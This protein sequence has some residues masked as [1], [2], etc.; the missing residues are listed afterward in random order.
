MQ[1]RNCQTMHCARPTHT[2]V[3]ALGDG[4]CLMMVY[5]PLNL[6][7]CPVSE[8]AINHSH[9]LILRFAQITCCSSVGPTYFYPMGQRCR[10]RF[11]TPH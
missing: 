1:N 9:Y 2:R 8:D 10:Q 3:G 7:F 5:T 6:V 11:M 4:Y